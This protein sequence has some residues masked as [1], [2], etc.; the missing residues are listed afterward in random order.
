MAVTAGPRVPSQRATHSSSRQ[1][2]RPSSHL[3][4]PLQPLD[5]GSRT[6]LWGT[7]RHRAQILVL[8]FLKPLPRGALALLQRA[9]G[10][11]WECKGQ[12]AS[13]QSRMILKGSLDFLAL[14][15]SHTETN[16]SSP[17]PITLHSLPCPPPKVWIGDLFLMDSLHLRASFP[18][19]PA[20][21]LLPHPSKIPGLVWLGCMPTLSWD[22]TPGPLD[23][24]SLACNGPLPRSDLPGAECCRLRLQDPR[25]EDATEEVGTGFFGHDTQ[26]S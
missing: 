12:V 13:I 23:L 2:H 25:T 15:G 22:H 11:L 24:Q 18:G 5:S 8:E 7:L 20:V 10:G 19:N 14:V 26:E 17:L 3:L 21:V 16:L 1:A 9:T 4:R 6:L